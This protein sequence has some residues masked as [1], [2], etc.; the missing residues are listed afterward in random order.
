MI[1]PD[2]AWRHRPGLDRLLEALGAGEGGARFVGGAVRD[3]VLGQAVKDVDIA[4][5]H[6]PL[7]VLARLKAAGIKA[8]PTGVDHGTVTAVLDG[9]PVEVTTLRRD[10]DTDGRHATVAFTDDWRED[11]AR[12]DFTI[13]ALY[14]DPASGRIFD[15]FSGLDHL[16]IG[17]IRFIGNAEDR[18]A[19]DHLRILRFFRF[20]ARY[21]RGEIDTA[22]Y[23]ACAKHANSLKALSRERIADEMMKLLALDAPVDAVRRMVEGGILTPVLPEIGAAGVDR[24]SLLIARERAA[25]IEGSAARRLAALVRSGAGEAVAARL[26]LSTRL[27]KRVALAQGKPPSPLAGPEALAYRAGTEGAIDLILLDP[28]VDAGVAKQLLGWERPALPFGGG[29]LVE[30]GLSAGPRIAR[31]YQAVEDQWIGEG[32]PGGSRPAEIAAQ[33]VSKFQRAVQ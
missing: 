28:A 26:K 15:Y 11:A 29:Y 31:A 12:R 18:I 8:V 2:A 14:A 23:A 6:A 32:F 7:D 5:P 16:H 30:L 27:R 19:E 21:G 24:L 4:T 9:W 13:N 1:L 17:L 20:F 25:G 22:G 10:V 3:T 33:I